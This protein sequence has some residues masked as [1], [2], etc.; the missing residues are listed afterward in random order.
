MPEFQLGSIST[1]TLRPEDLL[2]VF[3]DALD[4]LDCKQFYAKVGPSSLDLYYPSELV[5]SAYRCRNY[6]HEETLGSNPTIEDDATYLIN[7]ELPNALQA[8][9]PPFVYFGSLPGD[10]ADF[11][12]W[13]DMDSLTEAMQNMGM[14]SEYDEERLPV[15]ENAIA[16]CTAH[17]KENNV[18]VQVSDYGNVTVMDMERNVLWSLV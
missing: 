5:F 3:A 18:I 17:W 8:H 10:D 7:E 6:Y 12:F 4:S 11:G 16:W 1:G 15:N 9:C 14:A 13:P 2:P